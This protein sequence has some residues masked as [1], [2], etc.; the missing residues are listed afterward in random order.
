[1]RPWNLVY[2]HI[3]GTFRCAWKWPLWAKFSGRFWPEMVQN[4]SIYKF[5]S[6]FLKIFHWIHTKLDLYARWSYFCRYVKERPRR[7]KIW[8]NLGLPNESKLRFSTILLKICIRTRISLALY[9]HWGYFQRCVQYGPRSNFGDIL[10]PEVSQN[11]GLL[12]LSQKVF[13]CFT[14]VL[15][16]ILIASTF[17]SVENMG[18][19]SP[20]LGPLWAQNKFKKSSLWSFF[21]KIFMGFASVLVYMSICATFTGM[22][23]I[24][25]RGPLSSSFWAQSRTCLRS[26]VIIWNIF[27]WFHKILILHAYLGYF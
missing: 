8:G 2:R 3:V 24:G 26:L 21:Q 10:N 7:F 9:A 1:M 19:K 11:S 4:R 6:I 23:N 5:L 16:H 13:S 27:H 25:L 12:S 20:I 17:R 14:P 22:L 18:L 15:L